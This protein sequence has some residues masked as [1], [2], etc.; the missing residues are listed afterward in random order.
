MNPSAV[1]D[2]ENYILRTPFF[3]KYIQNINIQDFTMNFKHFFND[4]PTIASL[5]ALFE[6]NFPFFS[7]IYQIN[8]KTPTHIKPNAVRTLH[9]PLKTSNTIKLKTENH[10]PFYAEIPQTHFRSKLK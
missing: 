1:A 7:G 4:Q 9:F 3:E 8:S 6:T 2:I 10:E 5:T